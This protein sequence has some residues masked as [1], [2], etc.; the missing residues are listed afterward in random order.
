MEENSYANMEDTSDNI[1]KITCKLTNGEI[2]V[3]T[4]MGM[5]FSVPKEWS[6]CKEEEK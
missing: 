2:L 1:V 5:S 3:D 6:L 4:N